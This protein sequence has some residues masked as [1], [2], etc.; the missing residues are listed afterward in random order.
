MP[1][2]TNKS[3]YKY[4]GYGICFDERSDFTI[5]N[6]KNEKKCNNFWC[7]YVF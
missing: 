1:H 2:V 5:G 6:I 7:K 3:H 4:F